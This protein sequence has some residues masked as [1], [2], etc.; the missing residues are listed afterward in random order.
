MVRVVLLVV[1]ASALNLGL[2]VLNMFLEFPLFMDSIGTAAGAALLGPGAGVAIALLTQA[3]LEAVY[4]FT[5]IFAPWVVCSIATALIVGLA[6]RRGFFDAPYQAVLVAFSVS[7]ANALLGALV[8]VLLFDGFS[9]HTTDIIV[10]G[11]QLLTGRLFWAALWARIPLNLLD[12]GL[13]VAVA[14]GLRRLVVLHNIE[15]I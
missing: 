4:G 13:A 9:E 10:Q 5:W 15:K 6:A 12:K 1:A 8:H 7:L 3:A 11:F 14:Y 2:A